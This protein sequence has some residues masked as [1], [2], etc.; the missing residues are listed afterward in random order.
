MGGKERR[1]GGEGDGGSEAPPPPATDSGVAVGKERGKDRERETRKKEGSEPKHERTTKGSEKMKEGLPRHLRRAP[2]PP[3][4][5]GEERGK[6]KSCGKRWETF[7]STE[8]QNQLP[9]SPRLYSRLLSF[10]G[11]EE[12]RGGGE[13]DGGSEAP[14]PPATDSAVAVGKERGKDREREMRKKEGS[15]P[16][17]ERTTEGSEKM[18]EGLPRHLRRAPTSPVKAGEERGKKKS[19]ARGGKRLGVPNGKT[20]CRDRRASTVDCSPLR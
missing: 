11:G 8:R 1:G 2:T 3:V 13:G 18:K 19:W 9:R 4:K 10:E 14:P 6:K 20:S 15:E 12:R 17:H 5:A 16:K 7:G